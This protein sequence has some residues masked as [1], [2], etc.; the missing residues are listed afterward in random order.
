MEA[1]IFE[2]M[3]GEQFADAAVQ[4]CGDAGAGDGPDLIHTIGGAAGGMSQDV[5]GERD[6]GGEDHADRKDL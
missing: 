3:R 5:H 2:D 6:P 4:I 1:D